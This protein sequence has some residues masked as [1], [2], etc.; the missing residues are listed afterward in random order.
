M[1]LHR[2]RGGYPACAAPA[3]ASAGVAQATD[4]R[5]VA[6]D[7]CPGFVRLRADVRRPFRAGAPILGGILCQSRDNGVIRL[8]DIE[9][10]L[11]HE[12]GKRRRFRGFVVVEPGRHQYKPTPA[13][14]SKESS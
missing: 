1:H 11:H 2:R 12:A 5:P 7:L 13:S 14:E 4:Q 6:D 10:A 3:E 8:G 9:L